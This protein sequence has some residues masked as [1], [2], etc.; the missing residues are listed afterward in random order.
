LDDD[1]KFLSSVVIDLDH[2]LATDTDGLWLVAQTHPNDEFAFR[3]AD[4]ADDTSAEYTSLLTPG[5]PISLVLEDAAGSS[6][7]STTVEVPAL[8]SDDTPDEGTSYRLI[9][10]LDRG[11]VRG[12]VVDPDLDGIRTIEDPELDSKYARLHWEPTAES[13]E[14]GGSDDPGEVSILLLTDEPVPVRI[15]GR[16]TPLLIVAVM[17]AGMVALIVSIAVIDSWI[18]ERKRRAN[19]DAEDDDRPTAVAQAILLGSQEAPDEA[20]RMGS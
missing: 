10:G 14:Q 11:L 12:T 2:A 5:E 18:Q 15:G 17:T 6:L 1:G 9:I 4:A 7:D 3:L 16:K 8:P 19:A 13:A 20:R